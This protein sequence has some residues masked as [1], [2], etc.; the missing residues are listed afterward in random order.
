MVPPADGLTPEAET[1][2]GG[3]WGGG[4]GVG[5]VNMKSRWAAQA[6]AKGN[7]YG[8]DCMENASLRAS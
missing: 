5:L 6:R 4:G 2:P 1:V 8:E 7:F 3:V